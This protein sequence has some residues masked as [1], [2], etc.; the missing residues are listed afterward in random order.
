[1]K[2]KKEKR[3]C[4]KLSVPIKEIHWRQW[5][6]AVKLTLPQSTASLLYSLNFYVQPKQNIPGLISNCTQLEAIARRICHMASVVWGWGEGRFCSESLEHLGERGPELPSCPEAP[7]TGGEP[8]LQLQGLSLWVDANSWWE[9]GRPR[10]PG[11]SC[12]PGFPQTAWHLLTNALLSHCRP[13]LYAP[14]WFSSPV[15]GYD[16][17]EPVLQLSLDDHL[18]SVISNRGPGSQMFT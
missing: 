16:D 13:E 6:Y 8:Q 10:G 15:C 7:R 18:A 17:L 1:M 2:K 11:P 4:Q 9:A 5:I 14:H 3:K 12:G